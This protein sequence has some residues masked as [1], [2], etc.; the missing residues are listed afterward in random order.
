M[1]PWRIA[2]ALAPRCILDRYLYADVAQVIANGS[3]MTTV[4]QAW[5]PDD[6]GCLRPP[7]GYRP[8]P[9]SSLMILARAKLSYAPPNLPQLWIKQTGYA[10]E[11]FVELN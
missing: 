5:N 3:R 4:L 6:A 9:E 2:A 10:F 7:P 1:T 8:D 11:R